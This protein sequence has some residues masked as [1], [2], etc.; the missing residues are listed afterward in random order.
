[1]LYLSRQRI[2][3]R[4]HFEDKDSLNQGTYQVLKTGK[5]F[6]EKLITNMTFLQEI[7]EACHLLK[8]FDQ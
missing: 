4:G 2:P 3:L 6:F 7:S 1:L 5:Y 8:K